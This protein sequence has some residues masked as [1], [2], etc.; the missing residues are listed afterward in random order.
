MK[1]RSILLFLPAFFAIITAGCASVPL[2]AMIRMSGYSPQ[3]FA[4]T[5]PNDI[6][7]KVRLPQSFKVDTEKTFMELRITTLDDMDET[8]N[9]PVEQVDKED[10]VTG[11]FRKKHHIDYILAITGQGLLDFDKLRSTIRENYM[12]KKAS[13]SAKAAFD[14]AEPLDQA[15]QKKF[16]E[17]QFSIFLK[18]DE[19]ED[20]FTLL[21]KVKIT[22]E[23]I[24]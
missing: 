12:Y 22:R 7:I 20:Y 10:T 9:F 16:N 14:Y 21:N 1:T 4:Q 19:K 2:T 8:Y 3:K 18:L 17:L 13:I 24:K 5:D 23:G 15:E 6:R 11:F